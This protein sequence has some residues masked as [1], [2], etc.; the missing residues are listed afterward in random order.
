MSSR[1]N[2]EGIAQLSGA[3]EPLGYAVVPVEV[4]GCLHLK[5]ACCAL[6]DRA[7][8]ANRHWVDTDAFAGFPIES[9][10]PEEP[11]A[12]NVLAIGDTVLVPAAYPVTAR[13]VERL[14]WKVRPVDISELMKAEAGL[15]CSSILFEADA[16]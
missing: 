9:V 13:N 2:A 10:A 3:L 5:S 7:I 4:R 1:T 15:T 11:G 16:R 12:A 14:G 6:G 8:L